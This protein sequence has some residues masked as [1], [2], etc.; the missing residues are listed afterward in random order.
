MKRPTLI[1]D[2][3]GVFVELTG[4]AQMLEWTRDHLD[5]DQL[6]TIWFTSDYV[7]RFEKGQMDEITFAQGVIAEYGLPV[8]IDEFLS[9]FKSWSC[10]LFPGSR[11]LLLSLKATYT[12]ASLSNTNHIHWSNLCDNYN[13]SDYF[14]H[15]FPSHETGHIKP[16][17]ESFTHV[18]GELSTDPGSLF[19]FDDTAAN[20]EQA[21]KAG[22]QAYQV[23]GIDQL[24]RTLSDLNLV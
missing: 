23:V 20:V 11:R 3:G 9:H 6:W 2:L 17:M 4:V 14:H 24:N 7:K 18:I 10:R 12:L 21:R 5:V 16:D 19:F 22:I 1:F 8:E 13:L 15:N